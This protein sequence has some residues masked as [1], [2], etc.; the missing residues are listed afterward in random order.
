[1]VDYVPP[2]P[3]PDPADDK[4]I[5]PQLR[6][7]RAVLSEPETALALTAGHLAKRRTLRR[8]MKHVDWDTSG[9][10]ANPDP[11]GITYQDIGGSETGI[12]IWV[13]PRGPYATHIELIIH[14][15]ADESASSAPRL[16]ITLEEDDAI[17]GTDV[18][19]PAAET[20]AGIRL[21]GNDL[22]GDEDGAELRMVTIDLAEMQDTPTAYLTGPR[23][24][25]YH[26]LATDT[27]VQI[28]IV[29]TSVDVVAVQWIETIDE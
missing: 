9:T 20:S 28:R 7:R 19:A 2:L 23:A 17:D 4:A 6:A 10:P 13:G 3:P 27:T 16:D 11:D 14:Y 22:P 5:P 15:R 8:G 26:A 24:L 21:E 1:M 12:L 18:D 29:P 25:D